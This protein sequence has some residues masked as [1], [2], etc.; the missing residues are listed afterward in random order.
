MA[1]EVKRTL[2]IGGQLH[3]HCVVDRAANRL[4]ELHLSKVGVLTRERNLP[5][6][7]GKPACPEISI[8]E[9][10]IRVIRDRCSGRDGAVDVS[11]T[12]SSTAK[13]GIS[14]ADGGQGAG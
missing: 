2:Q 12:R 7:D 13:A 10:I 6:A 3:L 11:R 1:D 4:Q 14:G 5:W 9:A 8:G